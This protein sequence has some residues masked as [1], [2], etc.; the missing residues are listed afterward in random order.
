MPDLPTIT[1]TQ[2]QADRLLAA[3]PGGV[4]TYRAWLKTTLAAYVTERER[5]GLTETLKTDLG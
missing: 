1:V 4:A 3:F 5:E 2:A